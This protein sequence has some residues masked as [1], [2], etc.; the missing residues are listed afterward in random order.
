[1]SEWHKENRVTLSFDNIILDRSKEV[2]KF[3]DNKCFKNVLYK[4]WYK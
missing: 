3:T 4:M 2:N 1:M